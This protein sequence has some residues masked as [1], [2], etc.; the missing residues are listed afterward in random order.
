MCVSSNDPEKQF[1]DYG[2]MLHIRATDTLPD[3]RSIIQTV[4]GRRFHV[5]SRGMTDGYY[6]ARVEWIKDEEEKDCEEAYN[7]AQLNSKC[8]VLLRMWFNGLTSEQQG[9]I[10]NALGQIPPCESDLQA[11]P[12]GPSWVWWT[13]AALPLQDNVKLIILRMTSLEERLTS[14]QRFLDVIINMQTTK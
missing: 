4:G 3:G 2:T 7:L 6:T 8:Y 14:I 10:L 5:L 1:E 9:C 12:N 11:L 13:L